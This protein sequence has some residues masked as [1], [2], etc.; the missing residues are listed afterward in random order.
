MGNRDRASPKDVLLVAAAYVMALSAALGVGFLLRDLPPLA[1]VAA[2]DL[3]GTVVVFAWSVGCN[4]TSM[5]DPYWSVAPIP[6]ALYLLHAAATPEAILGRQA[7]VVAL[8]LT[9]G[10]RLTFNWL[11]RWQGLRDEDWRYVD[12][13][14]KT[15]R[16]YWPA[17]FLGLHFMPT[18]A[19]YLGC[20]AL[21]PA[22]ATGARPLGVL[23]VAAFAVTAAAI[24]IE[25]VAD[26]QL[27][28]FLASKPAPT[29]VL[30]SG[31]WAV[32]RHPNYF[33]EVLFWWGLF[34]FALASGPAEAWWTVIGPVAITGLFVFISVPLID[35]RMLRRRPGYAD[36][37][38]RV[39]SL[40]PWPPRAG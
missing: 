1:V 8:V 14:T 31:L 17:S 40:V 39:S 34:L 16:L 18:V 11:R 4:N 7:V 22:L 2:A 23:D 33:G 38:Q 6:I 3:A 24:L 28:R 30:G 26:R 32:S 5:Y 25:T 9:W 13:R 12:V 10:V 27:H 21:Y 19:V 37:M 15:G 29:A 20:L 36:R 35:R